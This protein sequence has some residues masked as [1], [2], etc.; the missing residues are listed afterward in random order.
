VCVSSAMVT[1]LGVHSTPV[2]GLGNASS[3][4]REKIPPPVRLA[5]STRTDN[6]RIVGSLQPIDLVRADRAGSSRPSCGRCCSSR[7]LHQRRSRRVDRC[8][9]RA[10]DWLDAPEGIRSRTDHCAS[11]SADGSEVRPALQHSKSFQQD[12]A[13]PS[14]TTSENAPVFPLLVFLTAGNTRSIFHLAA[15][16]YPLVRPTELSRYRWIR[17]AERCG[18]G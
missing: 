14:V 13:G 15:A 17:C 5:R 1:L 2:H 4:C 7:R 11:R 18:E 16:P 9:G 3:S 12:H 8:G 6:P 10:Y